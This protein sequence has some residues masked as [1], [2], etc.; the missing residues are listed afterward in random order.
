MN[1][2]PSR[3]I[4]AVNSLVMK[5]PPCFS[6]PRLVAAVNRETSGSSMRCDLRVVFRFRAAGRHWSRSSFVAK[7]IEQDIRQE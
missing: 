2:S 5:Q 6:V 7:G 4:T 1:H 3:S